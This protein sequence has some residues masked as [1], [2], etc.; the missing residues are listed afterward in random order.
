MDGFVGQLDDRK[1]IKETLLVSD[2]ISMP[3]IADLCLSIVHWDEDMVRK[4]LHR[5]A[6][7]NEPTGDRYG[8]SVAH[9]AAKHSTPSIV[10]LILAQDPDLT[11][12]NDF[13][14]SPLHIAV[15][16]AR[17]MGFEKEN[18]LQWISRGVVKPFLEAG[19]D[20]RA[21]NNILQTPL[22]MAV[23]RDDIETVLL[24]IKFHAR[25][26]VKDAYGFT[27]ADYCQDK[28]PAIRY[29]LNIFYTD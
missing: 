3:I 29:A 23:C 27:P 2:K 14:E 9:I 28:N 21:V 12:Q 18:R 7:V 1:T 17:F 20:V 19:A 6:N 8:N 22:H 11:V 25:V 10:K 24:L 16:E 4:L 13:K 15:Q 26:D 5:G